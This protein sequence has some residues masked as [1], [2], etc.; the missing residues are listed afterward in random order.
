M[1]SLTE[2]VAELRGDRELS[3]TERDEATA[4]LVE[5]C[6]YAAAALT[7]IPLPLTSLAVPG[8]HVGMVVGLGQLYGRDLSKDGAGELIV[9]V[10]AT[11]GMSFVGTR[12]A[13]HVAKAIIPFAPGLL[14]AP[15][16]FASTL[17]LGAVAKAYFERQ[18]ELSD[19]D[20]RAIYRDTL[21]SARKSFDPRRAKEGTAKDL[22]ERTVK[23][24]EGEQA[25]EAE[26]EAAAP[27]AERA[28]GASASQRLDRLKALLDKGLIEP[29][30]Y[31]QAKG[32][33]V[34]E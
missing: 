8:I 21:Q 2:L 33:L 14:G 13:I 10:G 23:T 19:D 27:D 28:E 20:I 16:M 6:G 18:G 9:R 3:P 15:F 32:R 24:A 34:E 22:A 29:D 25:Q 26:P 1:P 5:T 17:G 31:E 12:V 7:L 4:K 11:V 30:E